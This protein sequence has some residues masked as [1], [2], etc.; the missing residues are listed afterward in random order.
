MRIDITSSYNLETNDLILL[1]LKLKLG[2]LGFFCGGLFLCLSLVLSLFFPGIPV[3]FP[4]MLY[5][6]CTRHNKI[7]LLYFLIMCASNT[8][9]DKCISCHFHIISLFIIFY[10]I[11]SLFYHAHQTDPYNF[12]FQLIYIPFNQSILTIWLTHLSRWLFRK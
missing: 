2:Y 1:D 5:R 4:W 6:W 7:M 9:Y 8:S 12:F 11:L 10:S 3:V